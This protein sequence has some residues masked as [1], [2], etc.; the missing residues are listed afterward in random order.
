MNSKAE[1]GVMTFTNGVDY[2]Y[3]GTVLEQ[4]FHLSYPQVFCYR[5]EYYMIPEAKGSNCVLLYKA[6]KFPFGWNICDTLIKNVAYTDPSIYLSDTLNIMAVS[7]KNL[8]LYLYEA[9]SLFGTWRFH[10]DPLMTN[11]SEAR[12]GGRFIPY[13]KKLLL[14]LQNCTHGYGYGV[15]MYQLSTKNGTYEFKKEK[16]LFLHPLSE[17]KEFEAGMHHIDIQKIDKKYYFVYDGNRLVNEE[18]ELNIRGTLKMNYLDL[19][20]LFD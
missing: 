3:R 6:K 2:Q 14:P 10:K 12:C 20:N 15:S 13:N 9:D 7:D 8:N 1:I 19:K 17:I 4:P 11:G 18:K 16:H 5:N